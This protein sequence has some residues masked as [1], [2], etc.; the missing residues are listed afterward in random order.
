M[1]KDFLSVRDLSVYEFNALLDM[2]Q[3]IKEKPAK[4]RNRLDKKILAI[5]FQN[6][7][8]RARITIEAGLLQ[9]GGEAVHLNP[10]A[11]GLASPEAVSD[12]GKSLERWVDGI[13]VE[14]LLHQTTAGLA[15][16]SSRPVI[17]A[18]S[19]RF[20]PCQAMADFFTLREKM[21]DLSKLTI[22][23]VGPGGAVCYSLMLAAARAGSRI[24]I[25]APQE[26]QPDL[27]IIKTAEDI[28]RE[29]GYSLL[30]THDPSEAVSQADAVYTEAWASKA[31]D[32]QTEGRERTMAAYQINKDKMSKAKPRAAFMH[33]LPA[34]RG[35]EVTPEIIDSD[36]SLVFQ[37]A[38]NRLHI[39]KAIMLSLLETR[40][41]NE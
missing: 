25:A 14:G 36:I 26:Y 38:E 4:F 29:N 7:S 9:L 35:E 10:G 19:D 24:Q 8:P 32:D 30:L 28:G 3:K 13:V 17:N 33:P 39:Q 18:L 20:H 11:A 22:A 41:K 40:I 16:S 37:Q 6:A 12:L 27:D 2:A 34:S 15:A 21:G 23:Y 31:P 5:V 1:P